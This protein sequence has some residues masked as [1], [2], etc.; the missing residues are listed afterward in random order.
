MEWSEV[1]EN[2]LFE[3]LPFKIEL[4]SDEDM[5][6]KTELYLARGAQEVWLVNAQGKLRFFSHSG[7]LTGS[8][9]AGTIQL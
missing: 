4:N 3:N 5:R 6:I 2:P 7:E 8:A 1:I 9:R